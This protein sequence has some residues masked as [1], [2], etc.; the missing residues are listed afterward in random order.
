MFAIKTKK[1]AKNKQT[2]KHVKCL[3]ILSTD[4]KVS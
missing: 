1:S 3:I 2:N 4:D